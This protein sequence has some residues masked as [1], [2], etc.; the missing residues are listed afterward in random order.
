[1]TSAKQGCLLI[2]SISTRPFVSKIRQFTI[3][4]VCCNTL[5]NL[6]QLLIAYS[7]HSRCYAIIEAGNNFN[8]SLEQ[9]HRNKNLSTKTQDLLQRY[10][11]SKVTVH[12]ANIFQTITQVRVPTE[13]RR[14]STFKSFIFNIYYPNQNT[15]KFPKVQPNFYHILQKVLFI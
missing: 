4:N 9:P 3:V 10:I 7:L 14:Q 2:C 5:Y 11:H 15:S 1:M 6:L 13:K 8:L 12:A